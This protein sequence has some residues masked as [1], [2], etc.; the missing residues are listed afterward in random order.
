MNVTTSAYDAE[1]DIFSACDRSKLV[2][3][4]VNLVT[5]SS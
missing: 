4:P 2:E 5:G 3:M 1:K